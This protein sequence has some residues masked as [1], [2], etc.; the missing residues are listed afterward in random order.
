ML[1]FEDRVFESWRGVYGGVGGNS[2][3]TEGVD[4]PSVGRQ[5]IIGRDGVPFP[6]CGTHGLARLDPGAP[7]VV[8]TH[9]VSSAQADDDFPA[10]AAG[11]D[12]IRLIWSG[13]A[14]PL[15]QLGMTGLAGGTA[16]PRIR[17]GEPG[18]SRGTGDGSTAQE[19]VCDGANGTA[20]ETERGDAR[21]DDTG[22][23]GDD[24]SPVIWLG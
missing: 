19:T 5:I 15:V 1:A 10:Q 8:T 16:P 22:V 23:H 13:V 17:T 4:D 3:G 20:R 6:G 2:A 11:V 21:D 18:T 7:V 12:T 24:T 9:N 14:G